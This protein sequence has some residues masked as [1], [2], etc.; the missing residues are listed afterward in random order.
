MGTPGRGSRTFATI[1][2]GSSSGSSEVRACVGAHEYVLL[3]IRYLPASWAAVNVARNLDKESLYETQLSV[4]FCVV[5]RKHKVQPCIQSFAQTIGRG[6]K[7]DAI[8]S[9]PTLYQR[10]GKQEIPTHCVR[11]LRVPR[12]ESSLSTSRPAG[13]DGSSQSM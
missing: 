3:L 9:K 11:A 2:R 8:H 7:T 12:H 13:A 10:H 1:G 6:Q 5:G 4:V